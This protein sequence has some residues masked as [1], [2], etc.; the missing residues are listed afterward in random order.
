L[1][2]K[3]LP[4]TAAPFWLRETHDCGG[5]W[6]DAEGQTRMKQSRAWNSSAVSNQHWFAQLTTLFARAKNTFNTFVNIRRLG[7]TN[8]AGSHRSELAKFPKCVLDAQ[9]V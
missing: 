7:D 2:L 8:P 9:G 1:I 6:A 5:F 3:G 4:E